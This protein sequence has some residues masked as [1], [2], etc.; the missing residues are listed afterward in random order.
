M[1]NIL[2]VLKEFENAGYEAYFVGGY[3]RDLYMGLSTIDYDITTSATPKEIKEIFNEVTSDNYGCVN[4]IY[5]N[6]KFQATTYRKELKYKDNRKPIEIEYINDLKIDLMRRDFTINTLCLDS[7]GNLLDYLNGKED[8]DNKI[9]KVVGNTNK[10]LQE[11]ALRI[12][13]A[14]RFATTLNFKLSKELYEGI[15]K[16]GYLVEGLSYDRKK[17]ELD[18]IFL[19]NNIDYGIKLIRELDLERPLEINTYNLKKTTY[20][21]GIWAQLNAKNYRFNK[22]EA[23]TI[24]QVNNLLKLD[25]L[26]KL[27]LYKYGLYISSIAAEIKG[28]DIDKINLEYNNLKIKDR[29]DIKI[30]PVE[31][32]DVINEEPSAILNDILC[33][34]EEKIIYE[35][36]E[37]DKNKIIEYLK[38]VY[39]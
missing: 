28:I 26:D 25:I 23:E 18:K 29:N 11:D 35:K 3:P 1:D 9:I 19:S 6:N 4:F 10:K 21:V 5:K 33:D 12:L 7:N 36:L 31:I 27:N 16:Y 30:T 17:E 32:C 20:L 24:K 15:K 34:L 22:S 2:D 13:R 37:N 38:K 39:L 8:I 14:I